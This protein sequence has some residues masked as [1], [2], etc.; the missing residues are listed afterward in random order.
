MKET[1]VLLLYVYWFEV[2]LWFWLQIKIVPKQIQSEKT[3]AE[4]DKELTKLDIDNLNL[5]PYATPEEL[6]RGKLPP[7]EILSL[8]MFKVK[9]T[10]W[11]IKAYSCVG[12]I[13]HD[14]SWFLHVYNYTYM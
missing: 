12:Y 9:Q 14:L 7:E 10:C 11:V 3:E 6:E 5:K 2:W 4:V 13:S 8:P 1:V